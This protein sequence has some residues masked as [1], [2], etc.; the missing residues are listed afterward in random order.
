MQTSK[1]ST[2][3]IRLPKEIKR[4]VQHLLLD[5]DLTLTEL[6]IGL[7]LDWASDE[8]LKK[9]GSHDNKR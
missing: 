9:G 1:T 7:L 6:V 2:I 3:Y 5:K 8:E 4:R